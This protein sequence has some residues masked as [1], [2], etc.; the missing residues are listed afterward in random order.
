MTMTR[1]SARILIAVTVA[2]LGA[3]V[4][5]GGSASALEG[6]EFTLPARGTFEGDYG[7]I[8]AP[9]PAGVTVNGGVTPE[10]CAAMP[11]CI[12]VPVNIEVPDDLAPADDFYAIFTMAFD[13]PSGAE[14][15]DTFLYDDGQKAEEEGGPQGPTQIASSASS[16][17]PEV[18]KAFDP[19]YGRYNLV[20]VN[21]T[22]AGIMVHVKAESVVS[23]FDKPFESLAPAPG[24]GGTVNR[25]NKP[26]TTTTRPA[27]SAATT[28]TVTVPE[29]VVIPDDD[30]EGGAFAPDESEFDLGAAS[31]F[32]ASGG[33]VTD[34]NPDG[35][36][37]SALT[38]IGWMVLLPAALV[39]GAFLLVKRTRRGKRRETPA[40]A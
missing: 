18:I 31:D 8:P 2:L 38:L 32:A 7:P 19:R 40:P 6:E 36:S 12:V 33:E 39:G 14:D 15:L 17:N 37:P 20:L 26:T 1:T 5:V 28:T 9:D 22:G 27:A 29:G 34:L 4:L 21:F 10:E 23:A 35:E 11:S 3:S 30:F 13:A 24:G 16:D 25:N